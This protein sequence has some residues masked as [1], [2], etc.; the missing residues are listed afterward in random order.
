MKK[1]IFLT[2]VVVLC[3]SEVY[4]QTPG[5]PYQAVLLNKDAGQE[6]PGS[7]VEYA[8]PLRNTLVSIRF[9]IYDENGLEFSENHFDVVVDG[10]GMI[11]LIVGMGTYT[12]SDFENMDWDGEEK[13]L[14]IEVDFDN[15]SDFEN[16]ADQNLFS[17]RGSDGFAYFRTNVRIDGLPTNT[18]TNSDD[19]VVADA[20]GNLKTTNVGVID[21]SYANRNYTFTPKSGLGG[22][23]MIKA[24]T[25]MNE[26]WFGLLTWRNNGTGS[27]VIASAVLTQLSQSGN[28][29][30][31]VTT[32]GSGIVF[33]WTG[34]H[35]NAHGWMFTIIE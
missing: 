3:V 31:T 32:S 1:L 26:H 8:N 13:W 9:S 10:Y 7:D 19:M 24:H 22:I 34:Q 12:F 30:P 33:S 27:S 4:S 15:G 20:N 6:L 5:I 21:I 28:L 11:N 17:I 16:A 2:L 29:T 14:K 25:W 35:S 18:G 23:A